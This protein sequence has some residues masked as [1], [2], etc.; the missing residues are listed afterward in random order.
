M[1]MK[2]TVIGYLNGVLV[3]FG[4][5][6]E[7]DARPIPGG[8][9]SIF[10]VISLISVGL[11]YGVKSGS[12]N[13]KCACLAA[14]VVI[15]LLVGIVWLMGKCSRQAAKMWQ[16]NE[17]YLGIVSQQDYSQLPE[18]AYMPN[19]YKDGT[20][21]N[22]KAVCSCCGHEVEWIV[23]DGIYWQGEDLPVCPWCVAGG[24]ASLKYNCEFNVGWQGDIPSETVNAILN[25]T[26]SISGWQEVRWEACCNDAML[27]LEAVKTKTALAKY[28]SPE[29]QRA[30]D[31]FKPFK[32]FDKLGSALDKGKGGLIVHVFQCS[33]CGQ[34]T[35]NFDAD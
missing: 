35:L 5:P 18:F 25:R 6:V 22:G 33:H 14:L 28:R 17:R 10:L 24:A 23:A 8:K 29:F 13:V 34:Y 32:D 27:Y 11:L 7:K 15:W 26:P 30:L 20:I 2:E 31:A 9:K 3:E 19:A 1:S 4:M 16:I 12:V 21:V